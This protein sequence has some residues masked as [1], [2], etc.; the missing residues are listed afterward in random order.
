MSKI[1]LGVFLFFSMIALFSCKKSNTVSNS[2]MSQSSASFK[3]MATKYK[4][5]DWPKVSNGMLVFR[6]PD[7]FSKYTDFLDAATE[8]KNQDSVIVGD[9]GKQKA[10][11][12]DEIL[13]DIENSLGFVSVRSTSHQAFMR[14]NEIGWFKLDEIPAEHFI[15]SMQMRS[16]LN[17]KLD[18]QIGTAYVH[19]INESLIVQI[20]VDN[21]DL[22]KQY[23]ALP[24]NATLADAIQ[25]DPMH[26]SSSLFQLNEAGQFLIWDKTGSKPTGP[27][28][29]SI[30]NL[31]HS[32][33]DCDKPKDIL[34]RGMQLLGTDGFGTEYLV[35]SKFYIDFGDNS[36]ITT[37]NSTLS[38][39]GMSE[40]MVAD[41]RHAYSSPGDYIVKIKARVKGYTGNDYQATLDYPITVTGIV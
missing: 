16:V 15:N 40:V 36:G 38:A 19:Y 9:D 10:F 13:Q 31:K 1:K 11:D 32:A 14:L 4:F 34:F 27:E 6:D 18:V 29:Y 23:S 20:N 8:P 33:P 21:Y 22:F 30:I 26:R 5:S 25:L 35:P 2:L 37:L 39:N 28:G 7:H 41:F 12:Q 24:L 3:A 17:A